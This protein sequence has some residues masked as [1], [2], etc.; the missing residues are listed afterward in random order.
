LYNQISDEPGEASYIKQKETEPPVENAWKW[1]ITFSNVQFVHLQK[2]KPDTFVALFYVS[3]W[4]GTTINTVIRATVN[5][6]LTIC[7]WKSKGTTLSVIVRT[8]V[9]VH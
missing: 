7:R 9:L 4:D 1:A 6:G 3:N 2:M 8:L 5:E